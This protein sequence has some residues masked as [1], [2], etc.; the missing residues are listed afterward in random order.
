VIATGI[1]AILALGAVVGS[2]IGWWKLRPGPLADVGI[3]PIDVDFPLGDGVAGTWGNVLPT[4][5]TVEEMTI[6]AIELVGVRGVTILG[7]GVN[8]PTSEGGIGTAYEYPPPDVNTQPVADATLPAVNSEHPYVQLLVGVER[9]GADDGTIE[10]V[11]IRY[12]HGGE[13][14]EV[15][16]P[17][18]L[19][20]FE[21]ES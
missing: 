11:R 19:R 8:D 16:L 10:A 7:M 17:F 4:N 12:E 6:E 1:V 2:E 9:T 18:S 3:S 21:P 13:E 14:Y 20:V 15:T 5:P